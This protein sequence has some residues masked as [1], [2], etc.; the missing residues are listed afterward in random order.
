MISK[1]AVGQSIG[2]KGK[3]AKVEQE[4]RRWTTKRNLRY[5]LSFQGSLTSLLDS[6]SA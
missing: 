3:E 1:C 5:F 6:T 4:K 2:Q